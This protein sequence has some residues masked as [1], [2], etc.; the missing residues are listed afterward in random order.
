MILQQTSRFFNFFYLAIL[1]I[2]GVF[3]SYLWDERRIRKF[4]FS[5]LVIAGLLS[6]SLGFE[7]LQYLAGY[8]NYE[9]TYIPSVFQS[10]PAS[11]DFIVYPK[12]CAALKSA[13]ADR[14][15]LVLS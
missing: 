10:E 6:S 15:T 5:L 4:T 12:I 7:W 9:R 1:I 3:L 14:T 2:F 13:G 8:K 11:N